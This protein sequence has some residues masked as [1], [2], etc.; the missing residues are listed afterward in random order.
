MKILNKYKDSYQSDQ[1]T[2]IGRGSVWGN[3]KVIGKDGTR[4]EVIA[5][6]DTYLTERICRR[7]P[8]IISAL[9]DLTEESQLLCFCEPQPCHGRVIKRIW[10]EIRQ[11]ETFEEGLK[12]FM[13]NHSTIPVPDPLQDG[14]TH[15]N[16]YSKSRTGLGRFLSNFAQT[17]FEMPGFGKFASVEAFW[18][19]LSTGKQHDVLRPLFGL[20]AK[21][22][23]RQYPKVVI[24]DFNDLVKKA[25]RCKLEQN[26]YI[27]DE[28]MSTDLPF[29]HY[30]FFGSVSDPKVIILNEFKWLVQYFEELRREYK[31]EKSTRHQDHGLKD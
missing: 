13:K 9:Q 31:Y 19:W 29:D 14:V 25:I 8:T 15:I 7:D 20:E 10:E 28:M 17:P 26:P 23:G 24:D 1:V 27:I 16:I 30:Y 11:Y 2:Y 3:P 12:K 6:Y 5:W 21:K 4:E 22:V 18:Y